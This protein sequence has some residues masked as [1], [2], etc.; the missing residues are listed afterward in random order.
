MRL[1]S[2]KKSEDI[3]V[4]GA[5]C[6]PDIPYEPLADR[7]ERSD[8]ITQNGMLQRALGLNYGELQTCSNAR[9][10]RWITEAKY[11]W[12]EEDKKA[13]ARIEQHKQMMKAEKGGSIWKKNC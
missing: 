4:G 13:I 9:R 3:R 1:R 12:E 8:T 6:I 11:V 2:R 7:F 5:I 10:R